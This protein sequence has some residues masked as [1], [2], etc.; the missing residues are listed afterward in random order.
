M[1]RPRR[2]PAHTSPVREE[3]YFVYY[4]DLPSLHRLPMMAASPAKEPVAI[5]TLLLRESVAMTRHLLSSGAGVPGDLV[6]EVDRYESAGSLADLGPLSVAHARLSRLVAP[7]HP[8][9]ILYLSDA[10]RSRPG[11]PFGTVPLL[12]QVMMVS[13]VCL[14]SFI[15]LSLFRYVDVHPGAPLVASDELRVLLSEIF[16]MSAAGLGASFATLFQVNDQIAKR[17]FDPGDA[18]QQWI[19]LTLGV[20]A[21]FVLVALVPPEAMGGSDH[22]MGKPALAMLGG[23]S[24]SVVYLILNRLVDAVEFMFRPDART[25]LAAQQRGK[26]A[27]LELDAMESRSDLAGQLLAV[28]QKLASGEPV[29]T[30]AAELRTIVASLLPGRGEEDAGTSTSGTP[31]PSRITVPAISILSSRANRAGP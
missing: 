16:W 14:A 17:T 9:S 7:A 15:A 19:K 24:A 10:A 1:V 8:G 4:R 25:R 22:A 30:I 29:N 2:R 12:R 26:A 18:P 20:I 27:Q 5:R 6:R 31:R 3:I 21:G 11:D 28:Q 13:A 23:F